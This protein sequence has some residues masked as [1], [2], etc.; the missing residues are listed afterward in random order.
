MMMASQTV[1]P[2]VLAVSVL[3]PVVDGI[4]DG[5]MKQW[6]QAWGELLAAC[7]EPSLWSLSPHGK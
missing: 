4:C 2:D 1:N 5:N 3:L 7:R 6:A